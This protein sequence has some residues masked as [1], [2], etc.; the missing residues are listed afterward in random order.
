MDRAAAA[1]PYRLGCDLQKFYW[2]QVAPG[3]FQFEVV[4]GQQRSRAIAAFLNDELPLSNRADKVDG[5]TVRNL[6]FSE[7]PTSC[8]PA[9]RSTRLT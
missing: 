2:R 3:T 1:A 6:E 4:D 9:L 7:L 8:R 5:H